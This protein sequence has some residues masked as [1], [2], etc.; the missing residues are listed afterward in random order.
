MLEVP[1]V[2]VMRTGSIGA[3]STI[4][5]RGSSA[6][7]VRVF[8]D[9]V[10]VNIASGGAVD[11]STLPLGDV[12][13]VEVYRGTSPLAFGESALGGVV[14]I[15]TRTP[16]RRAPARAAGWARSARCSAT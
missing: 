9:G 16:G 2:T 14:S 8:V 12:E 7:E 3:A 15:T 4:T 11:M 1:G 10:P 5:L 6:D 13:R